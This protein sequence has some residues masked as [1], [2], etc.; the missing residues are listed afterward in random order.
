MKN[1]ISIKFYVGA[2]NETKVVDK[3]EAMEIVGRYYKGFTVTEALG[4]WMGNIENSIIIEVILEVEG[5]G[6]YGHNAQ[7]VSK[8]LAEELKQDSVLYT[9][10]NIK[11]NL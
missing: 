10:T 1:S 3:A 9:I 11:A 6:F 2:N 4:L 7:Q 5:I 8:F